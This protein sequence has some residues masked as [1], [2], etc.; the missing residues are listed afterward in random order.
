MLL[1]HSSEVRRSRPPNGC[2][3][4]LFDL[5]RTELGGLQVVS[6]R[7]I[8]FVYESHRDRKSA[9]AG[10]APWQGLGRCVPVERFVREATE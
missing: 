2:G 7:G 6:K 1:L 4:P 10:E 8:G 5:H 9:P 3:A